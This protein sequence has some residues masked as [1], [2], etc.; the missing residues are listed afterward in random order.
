MLR[1][2]NPTLTTLIMT[3]SLTQ[4]Q[5]AQLKDCLSLAHNLAQQET[6]R[7]A[8]AQ[9]LGDIELN[10]AAVEVIEALWH[11]L[12]T[13]RRSTAFWEQISDAEKEMGDRLTQDNIRLQQNYLR[14][15]Q[16][17]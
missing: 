6:A 5:L 12:L 1:V 2:L 4:N 9:L 16:E 15:M 11:E 10:P 8:M 17:Q 3:H 13:A 14:L 7:E